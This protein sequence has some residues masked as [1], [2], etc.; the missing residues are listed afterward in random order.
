M[1]INKLSTVVKDVIKGSPL[2]NNGK[3]YTNHSIRKTTV[4]KLRSQGIPKEDV[5]TVTGHKRS[6]S[7]DAYDSGDSNNGS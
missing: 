7:L 1:G 2:E 6:D 4:K 5:R 3:R